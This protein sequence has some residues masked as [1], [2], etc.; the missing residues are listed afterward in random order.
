MPQ[1]LR[2]DG[3]LL[4]EALKRALDAL[5]ARHE[6]LRTRFV[7]AEGDPLQHIDPP[8]TGFLLR[9]H[10][11][12]GHPD[13]ERQVAVLQQEEATAPFDLAEGPLVRGRLIVVAPDR[14][15]LLLTVHHIV[16]DGWSMSV[17]MRELGALY[18]GESLP[19][20][21]IQY[22]DYAARQREDPPGAEHSAYWRETLA[23]A[24]ELLELPT[25]RPRLVGQDYR[26]GF[27]RLELDPGSTSAL[28][29]LSRRGR[30]TLF[31]T[32][33]A[34]WALVLSRLSGQ[35][36]VVIGTPTANRRRAELEGLIGFF[37]NTL[38]LRVD[39]SGAPTVGELVNRA[40]AVA[41]GAQRHQDL[42]FEQV[43]ELVN[44]VRSMA[45]TPLF[46]SMF[47]WN[48]NEDGELLLPGI[49]V[50]RLSSPH[51]VAKFDLT[52][53]LAEEDGRIV[54]GIE[55]AEALFDA[56][57]VERY[58]RYLQRVLAQMA[59]DPDRPIGTVVL[60]DERERHQLLVEWNDTG[61]HPTAPAIHAL[62]EAHAAQAPSVIA[63]VHEGQSLTYGELNAKANQ[64][65]H[66]LRGQ[67][68]GPDK[69]VAVC[70][71]RSLDMVVG[72]L[73][74]LKA[75]G[76]YIPMD[77]AYPAE[78][79][80]YML[81]DSDPLLLLTHA[82]ARPALVDIP[83]LPPIVDLG[84]TGWSRLS[85]DNPDPRSTSPHHLAYVIY[86]S[87]STGLPK[88]VMVE[89][90]QLTAV[91]AGWEHLLALSPGL[92]H[93]QMASFS[94]DV[95]TADLVRALGFGGRLVL[96]PRELLLDS[97]GLHA[98]LLDHEVGFADF[99][100]AVLV[101]LMSYL[102]TA[103]SDL[104]GMTTIVCGSDAWTPANAR[105]L[106]ALTGPDVRIVNAYGVTEAAIDSSLHVVPVAGIDRLPIGRPLPNVRMY[107]LDE[108]GEPVPTGVA[109][110]IHIGGAG[111]AR[112]YLN[113]PELTTERFAASA[114][115]PGER[116]YRT[117]DLGRW[118]PGGE[119]EFLG[120]NDSQV[121]IR[122]FRVEP[123]EIE[124]RLTACPG[125]R[126]ATVVARD[127]NK[128]LVAYC[129]VDEPGLAVEELR[130][131]LAAVLP[132]HMVPAAFVQLDAWPLTPNGKI[133]RAALPAP[134]AR[135]HSQAGYVEPAG[136]LET[137]LAS[138]WADV[139]G[140][141][142]VG[143]HDHFFALGGHSLL[144][145]R[146]ASKIRLELG[147]EVPPAALFA[148]PTLAAFAER[149]TPIGH[150]VLPAIGQADRTRPLTLSFAQQRLWFLAQMEGASE[151][152]HMP[153]AFRLDGPL[154]R[155]ALTRALDALVARH[156]ALRTRF[157]ESE[158]E[159]FQEIV[160]G[161]GFS[162]RVHDLTGSSD[163]EIAALQAQEATEPFDL[164]RGPL[165]RGQL[166]VLAADRHVLLLTLHHIVSDGWSMGLLAQELRVLYVGDPLPPLPVQYADYAA[167]QREW[168]SDGAL[169]EQ[170][171]YWKEVLADAP[172]LLDLPADRSRPAEQDYRGGQVRLEFDAD[173][174]EA[175]KALG[176]RQ[177]STLFMV[178]LAGWALVLSR[179]ARQS[180]VVIGTPT[181]NR[182]RV[183]LEGLIGF[184]VNTLA[185]RVDLAGDPTVTQ[186]LDRV[187]GVALAAQDH[188]DIP[189]EQVVELLNPVR[190]LAH[191]PV[192]QVMFAWQNNEDGEWALPGV[193]M[194]PVDSPHTV[195]KFDL[196]LSLAEEN[197]R[198]A[199]TLEYA[200]ALFDEHTVERYGLYL[201]RVLAQMA[202]QSDQAAGGMTLIDEHE[203]RQ[204]IVECNRT[205]V[206]STGDTISTFFEGQ[207]A[208]APEAC[209]VAFEGQS[210]TYAELNA[211]AT[212]L[213]R[214]LAA[215][216]A[217]PDKLV[218]ICVERSVDMVVAMVAVMKAGAAYVPLD[219]AHPA[220]RLAYMLRD[221]GPALLLTQS[222]L[223]PSLPSGSL[224][225]F[226]FDT[227]QPQPGDNPDTTR[228]PES[229]AYVIYT[230]GSTGRPKGV[231]QTWRSMDNLIR[232]QLRQGTATR[233]L[234]FASMSFDVSFQEVWS[235]LCQGATLVVMSEERRK[236]LG[237]LRRF[238]AEQSVDRAFLPTAVLKQI[239]VLHEDVV[240]SAGCEIVTAGEALQIDDDVR[241]L[242][243][244]LGGARLYNQY[245]PTETHVATQHMLVCGGRRL[246]RAAADRAADGERADLC[247]R[248]T[249]AAYADGRRRR[250]V[251]RWHGPG[252]RLS[253]PS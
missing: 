165:I 243:T 53:V 38:P 4:L 125:V 40:R 132:E 119:L 58:G 70:V 116:L 112:G 238:L 18:A 213:A 219:P 171:A 45:H 146:L 61:S 109:G 169:A 21:P 111:V 194:A 166:I 122:G 71:E 114:F 221:S 157:T 65:A 48:N 34:G 231:A 130:D 20:L 236:D 211:K 87:G 27:A 197:G 223:R 176:R 154:D 241:D 54:G 163:A 205:D 2:L 107:V 179:L 198:I 184:F 30:S 131:R 35:S 186:L 29:A 47:A 39:L 226:C 74:V 118:L 208:R 144:A 97:A 134:D 26:G 56:K 170:G 148:A 217:G 92:V 153:R 155:A 252:A 90:S 1:A 8:D 41:L 36:D 85:Q 162:L 152:Y 147:R 190:S 216:G 49:E 249:V 188:Q 72:V 100:P 44:P 172:A 143:R 214:H 96:C 59:E 113:Q 220:D 156:E 227:D 181:A 83:D 242:M 13:V 225:V 136:P 28:K 68:V 78:R 52:L 129:L 185:L 80:A 177:G 251:C 248:R 139:L 159:A 120:R 235:T 91:A 93:L 79:L 6:A 37:V 76:A 67:G 239:A 60:L 115:V 133:D 187:R 158:G 222:R 89:H 82:P 168:L 42:P 200:S 103:G 57:T 73:A 218:A 77:P 203:Y 31:M 195:A 128:Q 9:V 246:A 88:G 206:F 101:P 247:P 75:G 193:E 212:R 191:S 183:E 230:S 245:G 145:M 94:F 201:H 14:H 62:F 178:L 110:E 98:F 12:A 66:H 161:S 202:E 126:E 123:G 50:T 233:V 250:A 15:V 7:A 240:P 69:L 175:L 105:Q 43:V 86:T 237:R 229:L 17:F 137:A 138:L 121:K 151:A 81:R 106:R 199:G 102:D 215:S 207:V 63:V 32:L 140:V 150:E 46:Q 16:S 24:L 182:R 95:F 108:S 117:G 3:P 127:E 141:G 234:Q 174:T 33:L 232:W 224:P 189:F 164:T 244:K 84:A 104:T 253:R 55:Y 23:G 5:V 19:P 10:D 160:P 22:A 64:L 196:T 228:D 204:L 99:V 149:L 173:L 135:A 51:T 192:F 11:L 180:D 142:Q 124:A 210:L 25:D 209:A 167:W